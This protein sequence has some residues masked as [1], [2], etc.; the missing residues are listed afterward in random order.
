MSSTSIHARLIVYSEQGMEGGYLSYQEESKITW[1]KAKAYSNISVNCIVR[2]ARN[3][4]LQGVITNVE[5]FWNEQWVNYS[6]P[7]LSDPD[8]KLSSL[9]KGEHTGD[10]STD[11]RLALKYNFKIAY[12]AERLDAKFGSGNWKINEDLTHVTLNDGSSIYFGDQPQTFPHRP[13]GITHDTKMRVSVDWNNGTSDNNIPVH[14]VLVEIWDFKG[15]HRFENSDYVTVYD[16]DSKTV[17][18]EGFIQ[19]FRLNIFSS[20]Y[21]GHF[22]KANAEW[23]E[24]FS[25]N[26]RVV[27]RRAEKDINL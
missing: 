12:A 25:E 13:Y 10:H 6:D 15:L 5:I 24:Y 19:D 20:T 26:Y 21:E 9:Y 11:Q 4:D 22:E 18:A 1:Q 14:E 7:I 16:H 2:S 8:F 3:S 23:V 17:M 27:L